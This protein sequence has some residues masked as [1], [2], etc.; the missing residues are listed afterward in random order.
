MSNIIVTSV[1]ID[2]ELWKEAKIEAIRRRI[3]A[4]D[5]LNEALRREI[6]RCKKPENVKD[7]A[8]HSKEL[9]QPI[10]ECSNKLN[11]MI[12]ELKSH[13]SKPTDEKP[14][15][16]EEKLKQSPAS[17]LNIYG[18]QN[19]EAKHYEYVQSEFFRRGR[20][21]GHH[22]QNVECPCN[23]YEIFTG[24]GYPGPFQSFGKLDSE[25]I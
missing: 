25:R 4:A 21:V 15:I 3:T 22:H 18:S 17:V 13:E 10:V 20:K 5:L 7:F 11:E 12:K 2:E 16:L 6:E 23:I 1:K 14:I 9:L 8:E 24:A 19:K